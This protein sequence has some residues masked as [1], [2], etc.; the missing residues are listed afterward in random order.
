[1]LELT[2][3]AVSAV[4]TLNLRRDLAPDE[5]IEVIWRHYCYDPDDVWFLE[6]HR[7]RDNSFTERQT[8]LAR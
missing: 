8:V 5:A 6:V 2:A 3:L 4:T 1:M 7:V